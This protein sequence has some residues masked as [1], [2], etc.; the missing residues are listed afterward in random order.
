MQTASLHVH[1]VCAEQ[2]DWLKFSLHGSGA[3]KQVPPSGGGV[4]VQPGC[5]EQSANRP[6]LLLSQGKGVPV[7]DPGGSQG[8]RNPQGQ[9]A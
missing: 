9:Y 1:P 4:Q 8:R 6:R 3:A 2:A 5:A 7:Q